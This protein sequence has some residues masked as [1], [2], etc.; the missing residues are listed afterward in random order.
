MYRRVRSGLHHRAVGLSRPRRTVFKAC[1]MKDDGTW[2]NCHYAQM[3]VCYLAVAAAAVSL[4][5]AF[6]TNKIIKIL[7]NV[8]T[9]VLA[10]I[11]F[12]IPGVIVHMC[13]ME[14]MRCYTML[15]PFTRILS[16]VIII[17]SVISLVF[18]LMKKD[19][20]QNDR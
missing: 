20:A 5:G 3:Y 15:Q 9:A 1:D 6:I 4:V 11:A 10:A 2:M 16:C 19:E 17:I 13:M 14:T 12:F 18:T 8:I 7:A